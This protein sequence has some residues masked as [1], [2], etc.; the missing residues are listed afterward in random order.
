MRCPK[1]RYIGFDDADRCRN[2]GYSFA[3]AAEQDSVDLPIRVNTT[4][5]PYDDL[6]LAQAEHLTARGES[7]ALAS[8]I[9]P[10][11]RPDSADLPL[12]LDRR[13]AP[14][15][16]VPA[17]P[18][19]PIAV[20]RSHTGSLK[21]RPRAADHGAPLLDMG[22]RTDVAAD[23]AFD[24]EIPVES[25]HRGPV[26]AGLLARTC[27][28]LIDLLIVGG[29]QAAVVYFTLR[30]AGLR[31]DEIGALPPAPMIAFL[32]LLAGGYFTTFVAAGGQSI[33][34][35]AAGIRVVPIAQA[36]RGTGRVPI[37]NAI[38]RAAASLLSLLPAGAGLVPA[39]LSPDR[40]TLHDRL[41]ETRV[42]KT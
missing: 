24:S 40:R 19:A 32:L 2:C 39:L 21:P 30:A 5:G 15:V 26:A 9:P 28:G 7:P 16:T 29:V 3:L 4:P 17:V 10:G 12:F 1:C 14:L 23:H 38:L 25:G 37:G 27:A 31:L 34:K 42:I 6:H 33:G 36:D 41:A 11:E 13:D 18:R 20:R 22:M 8:S 35:M